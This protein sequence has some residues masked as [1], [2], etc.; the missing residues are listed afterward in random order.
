MSMEIYTNIMCQMILEIF[1]FR[2]EF[3]PFGMQEYIVLQQ[4]YEKMD[5][6]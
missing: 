4:A 6:I 1:L 3:Y 2:K 5:I